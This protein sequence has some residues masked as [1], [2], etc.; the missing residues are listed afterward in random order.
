VSLLLT[1]TYRH[2]CW[3]AGGLKMRELSGHAH[4]FLSS[5]FSSKCQYPKP[6]KAGKSNAWN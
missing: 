3:D 5:K 6:L 2:T 4:L 1:V